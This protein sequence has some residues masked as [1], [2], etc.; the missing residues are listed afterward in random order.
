MDA[1]H[2]VHHSQQDSYMFKTNL[3]DVSDGYATVDDIDVDTQVY[4]RDNWSKIFL[5]QI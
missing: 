5:T 1:P 3:F 2:I 4:Y